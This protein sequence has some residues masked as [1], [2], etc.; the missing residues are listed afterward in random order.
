MPDSS[1]AKVTKPVP[2]RN[3]LISEIKDLIINA[4]GLHHV[5]PEQ[6]SAE[7]SLMTGGLELDSVD[8][9]EI[10]VVIEQQYG[11]KVSSAEMGAKYFRNIGTIADLIQTQST[12]S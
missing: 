7:T 5:K 3:A 1:S 6:L 8:I 4:V 9:L 12:A 10:V 11:I 2:E